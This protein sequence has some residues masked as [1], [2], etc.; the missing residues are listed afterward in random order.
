MPDTP[1]RSGTTAPGLLHFPF[2]PRVADTLSCV[3]ALCS[4]C[5]AVAEPEPEP[6][7][8]KKRSGWDE[9]PAAPAA[10]AVPVIQG[11]VLGNGVAV[12]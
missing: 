11:A 1:P 10:G 5:P 3:H 2:L 7:R 9:P 4:C 6:K 12:R 8:R